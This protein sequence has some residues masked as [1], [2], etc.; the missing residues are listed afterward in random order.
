MDDLAASKLHE[1]DEVNTVQPELT[2]PAAAITKLVSDATQH[3]ARGGHLH[4]R[5]APARIQSHMVWC[6][7]RSGAGV[8]GSGCYSSYRVSRDH[9]CVSGGASTS[10]MSMRA[11][12]GRDL[13]PSARKSAAGHSRLG[14]GVLLIRQISQDRAQL[15]KVDR[16]RA[17]RTWGRR[18]SASC[19]CAR[20]LTP[21]GPRARR[22]V[23]IGY[24]TK[25]RLSPVGRNVCAVCT[26]AGSTS[27]P[28][29]L[30]AARVCEGLRAS[31]ARR[32]ARVVHIGA[33]E[34]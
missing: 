26:R 25:V 32:N 33:G 12:L 2:P 20:P 29:G 27:S 22:P 24:S 4:L 1:V 30:G 13:P 31:R 10:Q 14:C 34:D 6:V 28:R 15:R 8:G 11:R 7:R 16:E 18:S 23:V 21:R 17:V 3:G 19:Q 9:G 5:Y